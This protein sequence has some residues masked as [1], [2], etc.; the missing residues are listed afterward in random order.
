MRKDVFALA[1]VFT[2][3]LAG[4]LPKTTLAQNRWAK[5]DLDVLRLSPRVFVELPGRVVRKLVSLR[6]TIPQLKGFS[7]R[8]N[9]ISGNFRGTN[10]TDWAVLCSRERTSSIIVFWGGSPNSYSIIAA[11]ADRGFLQTIDGDGTIGFSRK[12]TAINKPGIL[13][14]ARE[15]RG[16]KPPPTNHQGID[17]AFFEKASTIHYYFR[18]KWVQLQ[19]A[20]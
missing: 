20:D 15:F 19:G 13:L 17:D 18:G 3:I 2:V 10:Q 5:A 16:P 12:I 14:Y 9:V 1:F 7:D 6:C 4:S 8:H 11:A